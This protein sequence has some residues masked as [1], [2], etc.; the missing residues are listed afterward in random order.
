[1]EKVCLYCH[2]TIVGRSHK[3]YCNDVCRSLNWKSI[4]RLK[5][6]KKE[7]VDMI[8]KAN[9]VISPEVQELY[10]RIFGN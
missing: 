6:A 5:K 1:M 3:K 2:S 4:K 8:S 7:T 10:K 9:I